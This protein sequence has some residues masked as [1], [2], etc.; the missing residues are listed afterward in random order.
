MAGWLPDNEAALLRE[1]SAAG[2]ATAP[3]MR[4]ATNRVQ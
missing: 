2:A 1:D 3:A 4:S